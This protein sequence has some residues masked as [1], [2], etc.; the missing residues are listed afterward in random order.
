MQKLTI[1][2]K[3][4]FPELAVNEELRDR[5]NKAITD[6]AAMLD[7]DAT[8]GAKLVATRNRKPKAAQAPAEPVVV[9]EPQPVAVEG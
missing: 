3:G 9:D 4:T 2:I 6:L 8:W 7:V 1:E 5:T